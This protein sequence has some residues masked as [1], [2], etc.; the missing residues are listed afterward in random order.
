MEYKIGR[1]RPLPLCRW[2]LKLRPHKRGTYLGHCGA[3]GPIMEFY[4]PW[5]AWPL[6]LLHRLVFGY[7]KITST[8]GSGN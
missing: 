3:N 6:E 2:W 1:Q 4:V 8:I 7:A 5:W